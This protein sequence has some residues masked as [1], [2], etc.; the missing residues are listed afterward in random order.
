MTRT[1]PSLGLVESALFEVKKLRAQLDQ[2]QGLLEELADDLGSPEPES[3]LQ[4]LPSDS[5][6]TSAA[7]TGQAPNVVKLF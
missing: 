7:E 2:I 1:H 5:P 3:G 6:A 4:V